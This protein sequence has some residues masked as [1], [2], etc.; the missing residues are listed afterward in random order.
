NTYGYDYPFYPALLTGNTAVFGN[1]IVP[2]YS[3]SYEPRRDLTWETV[4]AKEI[5]IELYALNN[6]LHVEAAYYSKLTKDIMTIVP[7]GA[8]RYMLDNVGDLRNKGF[9]L[10]AGWNQKLAK[11]WS[12]SIDANITTF[13]N[14]VVDIGGNRLPAS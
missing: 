5:G 12:F 7:T 9:E 6:R 11:D 3:L 4:N 8:G 1:S 13:N 14:N 2:A 10:S